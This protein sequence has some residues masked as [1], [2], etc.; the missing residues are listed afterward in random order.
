MRGGIIE[1]KSIPYKDDSTFVLPPSIQRERMMRVIREEL[2]E[3]QRAVL[4]DYYFRE[5]TIPEIAKNMGVNK[6]SVC[7]TLHRAEERIRK[8]MKY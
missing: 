8:F 2:T 3:N 7:R 6:S 1:V 4:V 5:L